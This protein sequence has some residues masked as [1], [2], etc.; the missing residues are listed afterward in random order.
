MIKCSNEGCR[1][2]LLPWS[3][4]GHLASCRYTE[5]ECFLC[6]IPIS[7]DSL[8]EHIKTD[9]DT[10]WLDRD[11]N[12]TS[13]SASMVMHQFNSGNQSAIKLP[14]TKANVTIVSQKIVLMLKWDDD[15]GYHVVL[16]D[17]EQSN[18]R[19]DV[20]FTVRPNSHS[21]IHSRM[22]LTGANTLAEVESLQKH[23]YLPV[24]VEE[25]SIQRNAIDE[26][27][28]TDGVS[29]FI[30]NWVNET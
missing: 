2:Y 25:I 19:L 17:S 5:V 9:C 30:S 13:G 3:E 7:L 22:S 8:I 15:F 29:Q 16:I 27:E 21:I 1:R 12:A 18:A 28:V 23:A 24:D 14:D 11:D 20:D 10:E 6:E 4:K 26:Y